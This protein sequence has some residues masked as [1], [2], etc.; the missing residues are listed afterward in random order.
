MK[1]LALLL[2]HPGIVATSAAEVINWPGLSRR[3]P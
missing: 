2:L 1:R 3:S